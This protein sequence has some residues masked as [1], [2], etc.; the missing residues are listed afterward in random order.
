MEHI[1]DLSIESQSAS[2]SYKPPSLFQLTFDKM[3]ADMRFV[4]MV[5][6]IYGAVICITI[7]GAIIGI[8]IIILGL[9]I[10]EAADQFAIFRTT[11]DATAMRNGFELQGKYFKITKILIFVTILIHSTKYII[12]M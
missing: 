1:D 6:I 11:N 3:V 4:G 10:R 8:P 9:R 12:L 2:S 7:I 5:S